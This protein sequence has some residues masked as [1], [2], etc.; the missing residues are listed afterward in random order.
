VIGEAFVIEPGCRT[1]DF[2]SC[3]GAIRFTAAFA[4]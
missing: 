2:D 3:A 1:H 4:R